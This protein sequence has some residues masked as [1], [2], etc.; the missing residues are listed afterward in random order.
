MG[1]FSPTRPRQSERAERPSRREFADPREDLGYSGAALAPP[2]PQPASIPT[3]PL[4]AHVRLVQ[5]PA[6]VARTGTPEH[7]LIFDRLRANR[8]LHR[9]FGHARRAPAGLGQNV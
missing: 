1:R 3:E 2:G 6:L 5:P 9:R 4:R 7:G 8:V